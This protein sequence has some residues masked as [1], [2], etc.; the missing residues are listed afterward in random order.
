MIK[1]E[2]R[3]YAKFTILLYFFVAFLT[4]NI[5]AAKQLKDKKK[6]ENVI[7]LEQVDNTYALS[8]NEVTISSKSHAKRRPQKNRSRLLG[9]IHND[10]NEYN[11]DNEHGDYNKHHPLPPSFTQKRHRF[12]SFERNGF[13]K[14]V[15][16]LDAARFITI[17]I[18]SAYMIKL[19]YNNLYKLCQKC[20]NLAAEN[21]ETLQADSDIDELQLIRQIAVDNLL[22]RF[23]AAA[24]TAIIVQLIMNLMVNLN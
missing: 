22:N 7:N 6:D 18:I 2:R 12:V 1:K 14:D 13:K 3:I 8:D 24:C 23:F 20:T 19:L 17:I 4:H 15:T 10:D 9:D 16:I 11:D 5:Y 21:L